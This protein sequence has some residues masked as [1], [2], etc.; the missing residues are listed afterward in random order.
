MVISISLFI[1][2]M[3]GNIDSVSTYCLL[4][5]SFMMVQHSISVQQFSIFTI[6]RL[7][8]FIFKNPSSIRIMCPIS[9]LLLIMTFTYLKPTSG[10]QEH[11]LTSFQI[12]LRYIVSLKSTPHVISKFD[13]FSFLRIDHYCDIRL[14]TSQS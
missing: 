3:L 12:R 6:M 13:V 10:Y 1:L 11:L 8:F 5:K 14:L 2:P 9:P 7:L 4:F